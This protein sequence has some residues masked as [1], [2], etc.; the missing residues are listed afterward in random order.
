MAATHSTSVSS[1][2]S[3]SNSSSHS[4][5]SEGPEAEPSGTQT[6]TLH[7][8]AS[9]GEAVGRLADGRVVFVPG[10]AP[11]EEVTVALT[12]AHRSYVRAQLVQV[13][14]ASPHRVTPPCPLAAGFSTSASG[15]AS[16]AQP[17]DAA[18]GGCPLMHV[19]RT[20]Q[21]QAKQEWVR[22]AVRHSGA[23]VLPIL[24]PT[25]PLSYRVRA[26][27]LVREGRLGFASAR[28]H[29]GV[30]VTRCPVLEPNLEAIL[31]GEGQKIAAA[32]GEGGTLSGLVGDEAG[33]PAVHLWVQL[34][35][36]GRAAAVRSWLQS[37]LAAGR[38]AGA[39]LSGAAADV[40]HFGAPCVNLS[41][42]RALPAPLWASADGFAQASAAG[43]HALPLLVAK[44]VATPNG[45]GLWPRLV[46]LYAGSG[47]LTRALRPLAEH[48]VAIE[49]DA[50]AA[51]RLRRLVSDACAAPAQ[52]RV[53]VVA[54]PVERALAA[55][56]RQGARFDVAVLDPPR[57][58]ARA[59]LLTLARL[60]VRRV[61]YVSCDAM[62]LGRDLAELRAAGLRP[63]SVQP[64]DLMPHTA[65]VECIAVLDAD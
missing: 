62:T 15:S 4:C 60:A 26:R 33:R 6:L 17:R 25:P 16:G 12:T 1:S 19:E 31:L 61:V 7:E 45:G 54:A 21:L 49:G 18:C 59:A 64:L 42:R 56:F 58:G 50:A 27:L 3:S 5:L 34:A 11:G 43:H 24:A 37:L 35:P 55:L 8:L 48:I 47:N 13:R 28:S 36:G 2:S 51:G 39:G 65:Q 44:L 46:E 30:E 38:I 10:G 29:R 14:S 53:E 9:G 22:R 57:T 41:D 40:E 52:A 32:L 63:R 20:A 23:D